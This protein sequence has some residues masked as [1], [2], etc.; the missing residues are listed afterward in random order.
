VSRA[1]RPLVR[2]T[3][4]P[5]T[6]HSDVVRALEDPCMTPSQ[7][8]RKAPSHP[9]TQLNPHPPSMRLHQYSLVSHN[10]RHIPQVHL[11]PQGLTLV[12]KAA[13]IGC[14][15]STVWEQL[16]KALHGVCKPS[17]QHANCMT[18]P[19]TEGKAGICTTIRIFP[20]RLDPRRGT[21]DGDRPPAE[22]GKPD[23]LP[24]HLR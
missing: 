4:H 7:R 10:V 9:L 18:N 19:V 14:W 12:A 22:P 21:P 16:F 3:I 11:D 6:I 5:R 2:E 1:G 15:Q 8:R 13:T 20:V 17:M 23:W 24:C